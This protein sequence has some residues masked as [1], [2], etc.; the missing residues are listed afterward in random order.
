LF[1]QRKSNSVVFFINRGV[2]LTVPSFIF[3]TGGVIS[4]LGKGI[5]ASSIGLLLEQKGYS[6]TALKADPYL[7]VD[8]GTMNPIIHGETFV[9]DDGLETDQD[10]GHYER[11]LNKSL[12]RLNYM[13]AGQVFQTVLNNERMMKYNGECVE[14]IRHIPEEIIARLTK[15]GQ[16]SKSE[17]VIVEI[18]GTVGDIQNQLFLEAARQMRIKM[19]YNILVVHV[20]YL[21]FPKVL[22]ELKSKPAQQSVS[23][24]LASGVAPDIIIT[25]SE[26]EIDQV[27]KEKISIF[28][29]VYQED[30]FSNPDLSSV[31]DV[32]AYLEKQGLS[33]RIIDKLK[34][35]AKKAQTNLVNL[36]QNFAK[37][38]HASIKS[39]CRVGIVGKYFTSGEFSL[40][41]SYVCV[42]EALKQ[43]YF[44]NE[45]K[46][47]I[48]W[49]SSERIEKEGVNQLTHLDGIVVPQGWG[50]RGTEGKIL[51]AQY[52]RENQ[53]P[54]L[55]LCFGMQMAVIEFARN[56]L[57]YTDAN[58]TEVNVQTS[59]PVIHIM[60]NQKE[61]LAKHQYGGTIRLGS[62][63][64]KLKSGSKLEAIYKRDKRNEIGDKT[65]NER[66]RH[67]YEFNQE[68]LAEFENKGLIAC[69]K[70][71]DG[72]LVEA[73][74][75]KDHPFFIGVQF[76]PEY[77]SRP[78]APH[79]IFMA[80]IEALLKK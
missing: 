54:Y 19:R 8:A 12:N 76:H 3:V 7:N 67:R 56:V 62:W 35:P 75:L 42:L 44:W 38:R 14:M 77:L 25:R 11:F 16:E 39:R 29:N 49:L 30:I 51:T 46:P 43:A 58:S 15:L 57:G 18:G 20:V 10:I 79:P 37:K 80:F 26:K 71:P 70:S 22:G 74:E 33:N 53:V 21:P 9:T 23:L 69:A 34:L 66:H 73:I 17:I 64:A 59:H 28:C 31:Y 27:R 72:Q 50:S 47:D 63:P 5:T 78:M 6:V 32:P 41:D 40:E 52:C 45:T 13:T 4:G 55:G 60:E 24:L 61:Y 68:Y 2:K 1:S 65:V 36:W 48:V